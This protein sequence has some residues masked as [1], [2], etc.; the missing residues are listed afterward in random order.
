MDLESSFFPFRKS[1]VYT[2]EGEVILDLF[3]GSGQTA[4]AA[5]KSNRHYVGYDISKE[6]VVLAEKRIKGYLQEQISLF[7]KPADDKTL[8]IA[9]KAKRKR[10][11]AKS[12][13]S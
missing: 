2:F 7:L 6:Y 1:S 11:Q 13:S 8:I 3:M 5:L 12:K 9:D 10:Y 4:L